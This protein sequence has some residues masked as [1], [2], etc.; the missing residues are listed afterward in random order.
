MSNNKDKMG[1]INIA[2]WHLLLCCHQKMYKPLINLSNDLQI[3]GPAPIL[4]VYTAS[5]LLTSVSMTFCSLETWACVW[6]AMHVNAVDPVV[7][8]KSNIMPFLHE[9]IKNKDLMTISKRFRNLLIHTLSQ[10]A[11]NTNINRKIVSSLLCIQK[12]T[13]V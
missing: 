5:K 4:Q 2:C 1:P 3:D 6:R 9:I 8:F 13:R 7:L 12:I 11:A 10:S